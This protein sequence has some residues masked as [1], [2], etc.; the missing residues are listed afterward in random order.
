VGFYTC[1]RLF[2]ESKIGWLWNL[3]A[4]HHSSTRMYFLAGSRTHPQQVTISFGVTVAILWALGA[5]DEIIFWKSVL[6]TANGILQHANL[7]M[8]LGPLNWV[9]AGPELHRSHHSADAA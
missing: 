6:H 3:H 4:V 7:D 1:H 5:S 2:H 9:I 8:R